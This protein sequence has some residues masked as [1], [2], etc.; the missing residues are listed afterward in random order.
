[1]NTF[2]KNL[3]RLISSGFGTSV[4][5]RHFR[6][7]KDRKNV[8]SLLQKRAGNVPLITNRFELKSLLGAPA[9]LVD[10]EVIALGE[11]A[12]KAEN[13]I[14]EIGAAYGASS[15]VF[16]VN[17]KEHTK[18]YS[19]DPFIVDSMGPFQATKEKCERGVKTGLAD[20]GLSTQADRW[21]LIS[22]YS[23]NVVNNFKEKIDVIFIDGD[24]TYEAVKKDFE[25]WFPLVKKGGFILFHDSQKTPQ[26]DPEK[27]EKGWPGP[28]RLVNELKENKSLEYLS[29][30]SSLSAF[31][32]IND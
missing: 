8:V 14:V 10:P 9:L 1:M 3:Q 30:A 22:D 5:K 23:Y 13:V 7:I 20:I 26:S 19:I 4:I 12:R 11:F 21:H 18:L 31:R 24:H 17:K 32:K 6:K 2:K 29:P 28:T 15:L 27:Y 25:D 16:L